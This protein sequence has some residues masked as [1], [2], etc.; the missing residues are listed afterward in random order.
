MDNNDNID[1][2]QHDD[3]EEAAAEIENENEHE[4]GN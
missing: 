1:N 2:V 4:I 3:L